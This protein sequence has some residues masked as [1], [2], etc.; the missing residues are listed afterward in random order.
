[1]KTPLSLALGWATAIG[2]VGQAQIPLINADFESPATASTTDSV[3]GWTI[4]GSGAGV[5]NINAYATAFWDVPAPDGNQVAY[6]SP[7]PLGA[8]ALEQITSST[9]VP[10]VT[11]MLSGQVGHPKGWGSSQGTIYSVE[12]LAGGTAVKSL[13][14]TGPEGS[15]APFSVMW[16]GDAAHD[17]QTLGVRLASSQA[18]T[19][20]DSIALVPEP[21]ECLLAIG[22]G[23]LG[24]CANRRWR[25][26]PGRAD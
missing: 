6:V 4:T 9:V 26:Q 17:G 21:Q 12:I 24:F 25:R 20:Y 11:Y 5:W 3:T 2:M 1:M 7:T 15:F 14:G 23:L 22:F 10:G 18:Q 13:A 19:A 8:A 16:T